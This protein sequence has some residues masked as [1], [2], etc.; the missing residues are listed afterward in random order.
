MFA[1]QCRNVHIICIY[2]FLPSIHTCARTYICL[3]IHTYIHREGK[4]ERKRE[5]QSESE[6]EREILREAAENAR[7]LRHKYLTIARGQLGNPEKTVARSWPS[8]VLEPTI[9][10]KSLRVCPTY[11]ASLR[12]LCLGFS[13]YGVSG[14][15]CFL[16][17]LP[18]SLCSHPPIR[19]T[20]TPEAV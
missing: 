5:R 14:V 10:T 3:S 15:H 17:A 19:L 18:S 2:A 11:I 12:M 16:W 9:S 6:R 13:R 20:T 1:C 8:E 7:E 4:G